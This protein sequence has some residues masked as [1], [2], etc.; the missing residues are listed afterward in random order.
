MAGRLSSAVVE[1]GRAS[2]DIIRS[3]GVCQAAPGDTVAQ[4]DLADQ[5]RTVS[6]KV[7]YLTVNT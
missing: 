4:R 2:I 7:V 6:E 5:A 1:L 3:A